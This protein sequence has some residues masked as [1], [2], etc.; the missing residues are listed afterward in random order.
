MQN[1]QKVFNSVPIMSTVTLA[2]TLTVLMLLN[3][4]FFGFQNLT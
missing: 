4:F 2:L 1:L 3:F